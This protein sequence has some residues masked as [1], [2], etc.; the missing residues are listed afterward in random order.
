MA[1]GI[2][3]KGA[4]DV[5]GHNGRCPFAVAIIERHGQ[6][7]VLVMRTTQIFQ[8]ILLRGTQHHGLFRHLRQHA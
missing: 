2:G 6:F 8:I 4:T 1:F 3:V 7:F 5:G